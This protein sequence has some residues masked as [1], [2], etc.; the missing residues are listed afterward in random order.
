MASQK[1][2]CTVLFGPRQTS[3]LSEGVN[4][5]K[6]PTKPGDMR[7]EVG[8][9]LHQRRD[10][11]N[12]SRSHHPTWTLV[13]APIRPGFGEEVRKF[14]TDLPIHPRVHGDREFYLLQYPTVQ[15]PPDLVRVRDLAGLV[16]ADALRFFKEPPKRRVGHYDPV[17]SA[18]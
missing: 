2:P 17:H 18:D 12:R 7:P 8:L 9:L 15:E 11:M 3:L 5:V 10:A 14:L 13:G 4:Y 6:A 1:R 16:K